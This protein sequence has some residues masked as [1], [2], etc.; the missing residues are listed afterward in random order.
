MSLDP[1]RKLL[2]TKRIAPL[3]AALAEADLD[4]LAAAWSA[5]RPAE[6]TAFFKLLEVGR[7]YELFTRLP[8]PEKYFAFC[9][10]P[11]GAAAPLLASLGAPQRRLF[12]Q[13]PREMG[14]RMFRDLLRAARAA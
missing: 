7:A 5:A 1:L 4:A 14:E 12:R 3:K 13:V 8:L 10:L 2:R 6:K 9:A 11:A